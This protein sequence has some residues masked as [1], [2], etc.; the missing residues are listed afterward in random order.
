MA[1]NGKQLGD[2]IAAAILYAGAPPEVKAQ[3]TEIWEKIGTCIVNHITAN[4]EV[5]AGIA[6]S[7]SGGAGSTSAAGSIT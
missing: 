7:T 3:A 5:P 6:V 2:E 4:G 1:M